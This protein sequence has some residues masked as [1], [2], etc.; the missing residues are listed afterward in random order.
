M[1]FQT[2]KTFDTILQRMGGF[3]LSTLRVPLKRATMR[4]TIDLLCTFDGE[5][6]QQ[7]LLDTLKRLQLKTT[8]K[9]KCC[10]KCIIMFLT[11]RIPRIPLIAGKLLN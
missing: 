1:I 11:P 8:F 10:V 9:D 6:L 5:K 2:A 3:R 7:N 4:K